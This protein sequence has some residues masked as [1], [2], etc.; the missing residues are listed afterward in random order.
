MRS[1]QRVEAPHSDF[2]IWMKILHAPQ[3]VAAAKTIPQPSGSQSKGTAARV[4]GEE[5]SVSKSGRTS[6]SHAGRVRFHVTTWVSQTSARDCT[7]PRFQ[8]SH[9]LLAEGSP[10]PVPT[11]APLGIRQPDMVMEQWWQ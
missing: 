5:S 10:L 4:L 8:G 3:L 7:A 9:S 1:R 6:T 2:P 11:E